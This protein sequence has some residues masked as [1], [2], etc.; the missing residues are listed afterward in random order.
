MENEYARAELASVVDEVQRQLRLAATIEEQRRQLTATASVRGN[1]VSVTVNATGQL[2]DATFGPGAEDLSY[3]ELARAVTEASAQAIAEVT[4]RS[5]E[6]AAPMTA[7]YGRLP[8]LSD[9]IEGMPDLSDALPTTRLTQ[10]VT[11]DPEATPADE[12]APLVFDD[13]ETLDSTPRGT[14]DDSGW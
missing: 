14:V 2:T 6:L 11:T 1:R 4:R 13:T 5:R 9:L 12:D 10:W 7:N 8:K 3:A